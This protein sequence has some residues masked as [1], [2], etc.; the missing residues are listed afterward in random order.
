L[1]T[2]EQNPSADSGAERPEDSPAIRNLT[3]NEEPSNKQNRRTKDKIKA[4]LRRRKYG[5]A[6]FVYRVSEAA[7]DPRAWLEITALIVVGI[8]T[9]YAGKQSNIM[10]HT[11]EEI[12]KQT[13]YAQDSATAAQGTFTE[14]RNQTEL[15]RQQMIGT[16]SATVG[17]NFSLSE[18]GV[19][20][21]S[22]LKYG[23]VYARMVHLIMRVSRRTLPDQN[24]I[25]AVSYKSETIDKIGNGIGIAGGGELR[26]IQIPDFTPSDWEAIKKTKETVVVEGSLS[27]NDGFEDIAPSHF[28]Y[29]W[30]TADVAN[31]DSPNQRWN[32]TG[33]LNCPD[34]RVG[35][36][37]VRKGTAIDEKRKHGQDK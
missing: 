11:Y 18:Y 17:V 22:I 15:L 27:Y 36:E 7:R 19:L 24:L 30:L 25:G 37:T 12:K 20:T 14:A 2:E 31:P 10:S 33:F 6:K 9:Y 13:G 21:A 29:A 8:Y 5:F 32:P 3:A 4:F 35:L 16:Q 1:S 23:V 34:F 26:R 28:C